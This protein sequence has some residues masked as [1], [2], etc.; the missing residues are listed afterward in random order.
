VG[1]ALEAAADGVPAL[2]MSLETDTSY[3][4][5]HSKEIDFRAAAQW[6]RRLAAQILNHQIPEN[7]PLL[8]VNV[9]RDATPETPWRVTSASHQAYF[10]S[11][12]EKRRIVGYD[13]NVDRAALEPDSDI[14]A[15][16]VDRVVSLTPLTYDLTARVDLARFARKLAKNAD[17]GSKTA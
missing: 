2:A 1:A 10:R 11:R 15:L 17:G 5:S 6:T 9:P 14:Y 16:L 7:V 12:I 13:V 8:N 3:H 4:T